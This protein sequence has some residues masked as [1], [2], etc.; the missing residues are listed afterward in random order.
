MLNVNKIKCTRPFRKL[1]K[2]VSHLPFNADDGERGRGDEGAEEL[3]ETRGATKPA[4]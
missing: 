3:K 4:W 2:K 1:N